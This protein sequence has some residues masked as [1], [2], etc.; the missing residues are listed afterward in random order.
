MFFDEE[1]LPKVLHNSV[2]ARGLDRRD[3]TLYIP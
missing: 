2:T 3:F 1:P